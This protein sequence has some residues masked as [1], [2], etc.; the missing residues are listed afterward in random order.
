MDCSYYLILAASGGEAEIGCLCNIYILW[1]P[2]KNQLPDEIIQNRN[3]NDESPIY[4]F[5]E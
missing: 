2:Q 4:I 5:P 3:N 1:L